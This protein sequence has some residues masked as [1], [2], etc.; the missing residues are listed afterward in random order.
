MTVVHTQ[1][2]YQDQRLRPSKRIDTESVQCS[3][4]KMSYCILPAEVFQSETESATE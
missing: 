3:V 1:L 4:V 2:S